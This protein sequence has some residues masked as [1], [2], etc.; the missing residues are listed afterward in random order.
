MRIDYKAIGSRVRKA[1]K[2]VGLTQEQIAEMTEVSAQHISNIEHGKTK[3]SLPMIISLANCLGVSVD[4]LLSDVVNRSEVV[5]AK[6][7][8]EVFNACDTEQKRMIVQIV[9]S[10]A[11]ALQQL[12]ES[13]SKNHH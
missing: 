5:L 6:E 8:N 7:I 13:Y 1:R 10:S 12:K 9:K 11:N 2:N 3:L 4:S